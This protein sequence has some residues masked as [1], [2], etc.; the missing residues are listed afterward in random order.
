MRPLLKA[1]PVALER[2]AQHHRDEAWRYLGTFGCRSR[3]ARHL[4]RKA[5]RL[6]RLADRM[7]HHFPTG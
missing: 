6:E 5:E 4:F 2:A 1:N 7:R 3:V